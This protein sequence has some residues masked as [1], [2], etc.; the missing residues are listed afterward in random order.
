[1]LRIQIAL[2]PSGANYTCR[3]I[4]EA[5]H[6]DNSL[7][8]RIAV[9]HKV[10]ANEPD[11][12]QEKEHRKDAPR[13]AS[14]EPYNGLCPCER[15][16]VEALRPETEQQYESGHKHEDAKPDEGRVRRSS[17]EGRSQGGC[18]EYEGQV[19]ATAVAGVC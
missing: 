16:Q 9:R 17:I 19:A 8:G 3:G 7:T 6:E 15:V 12:C 14:H 5:D 4:V 18:E 11:R 10:Q 1:M 2:I 13:I